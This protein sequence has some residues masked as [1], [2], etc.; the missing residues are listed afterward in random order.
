MRHRNLVGILLFSLGLLAVVRP[1]NADTVDGITFTVTNPNLTGH[2]GDTLTWDYSVTNNSGGLTVFAL[3]V[4]AP[5]GFTGG[6]PDASV[7]DL[8]G[9]TTMI[10]SGASFTGTLFSF[11][12]DPLVPSSSNTG[13][14]DLT[15]LL[16]DSQGS[17]VNIIDLT[18]AYS[19]TIAPA[20][21]VP[22]PGTMM[23]LASGFLACMLLSR[24]S[25]LRQ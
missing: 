5:A 24:R 16:V 17:L 23:L 22:E 3:D 18:D 14:F 1:A 21:G 7:F 25:A 4:N 2:P 13:F 8:F 10:A 15:A 9:P 19:A 12:S 6:N 20:A 11:I